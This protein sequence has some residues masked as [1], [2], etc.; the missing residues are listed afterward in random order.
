MTQIQPA[1]CVFFHWRVCVLRRV[2]H[3]GHASSACDASALFRRTVAHFTQLKGGCGPCLQHSWQPDANT[4]TLLSIPHRAVSLLSHTQFKSA[5]WS[6]AECGRFP[7]WWRGTKGPMSRT[8]SSFFTLNLCIFSWSFWRRCTLD[9]AA[10]TQAHFCL[11]CGNLS[12]LLW[13]QESYL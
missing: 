7:R 5:A 3:R 11:L 1:T 12:Y 6:L 8:Y 9:T 13:P 2:P 4:Q 10:F